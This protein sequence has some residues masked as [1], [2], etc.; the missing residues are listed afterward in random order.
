[1]PHR[2]WRPAANSGSA[3]RS[4]NGWPRAV[5]CARSWSAS[6]PTTS[7]AGRSCELVLH[8]RCNPRG[9]AA[10][11]LVNEYEVGDFYRVFAL[12]E[13]ID[14]EKINAELKQ[15][16]LTVHLPKTAALKPRKITVRGN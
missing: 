16:V 3:N 10:N 15:G 8:G 4:T 12:S 14:A 7:C 2:N 13:T 11:F 5:N 9:P 1:M 6:A